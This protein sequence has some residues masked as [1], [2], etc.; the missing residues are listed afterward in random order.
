MFFKKDEMS[1]ETFWRK[2]KKKTGEK[3][4]ARG[5]GKYISGW[6][7]FDEKRW[8]GLWGLIVNTS[9]GFRFH[10][11]PQNSIF[12]VLTQ[13]AANAKEPPKEKTIFL[14][15]E[16]IASLQFIKEEKW[17]K[18]LFYHSAPQLVINYRDETTDESGGIMEKKLIFE[19]EYTKGNIS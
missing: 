8:N 11:F 10:H 16:K 1:P 18:R 2:K 12:D 3:V 6:D 9:G 15:Q 4:L 14:P 13:F 5:L 19:V 17:W 7:E